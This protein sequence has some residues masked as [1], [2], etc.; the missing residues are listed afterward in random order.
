MK[1]YTLA[2]LLLTQVGQLY[3]SLRGT[4]DND[5]EY[6]ILK[7]QQVFSDFVHTLLMLDNFPAALSKVLLP[8]FER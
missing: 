2:I 7:S 4:D 1:D 3:R 6:T 8:V 5:A